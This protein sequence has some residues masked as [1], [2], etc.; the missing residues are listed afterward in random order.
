MDCARPAS[1]GLLV[2]LKLL[3]GRPRRLFLNVFRPGYVRRQ[4]ARRRGQ[5]HRCGTCCNLGLRCPSLEFDGDGQ[6]GCAI[7]DRRR[8]PNCRTFP[9]DERDLADRDVLS[10]HKPCG[11][12]FE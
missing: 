7:Y 1:I 12:W 9:I 8:S 3:L 10:P 2:R 6:A 4:L 5:C 11:F